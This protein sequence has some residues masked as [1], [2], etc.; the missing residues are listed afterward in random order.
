MGKKTSKMYGEK[1]QW[2][3]LDKHI[4]KMY[5]INTLIKCMGKNIN[6][7]VWGKNSNKTIWG[8]NINK[9]GTGKKDELKMLMPS[10]F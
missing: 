10:L 4:N 3:V 9:N 5:G 8:K 7:N 1:H 6:K 2:N